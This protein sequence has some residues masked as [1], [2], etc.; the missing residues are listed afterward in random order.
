MKQKNV[1]WLVIA[2]ALV[3]LGGILFCIAMWQQDWN[4]SSLSTATYET[5]EYKTLESFENIVIV[6]NTADIQLIPA[7]TASVTC[8]E[9]EN[10]KHTV[11]VRDGTLYIE[12]KDETKWYQHIGINFTS[13][14]IQLCIPKGRYGSISIKGDTGDVNIPG[15][16]SF[17]RLDI[18]VDTGDVSVDASVTGRATI[19]TSTGAAGLKN[20]SVGDLSISVSTGTVTV[21]NVAC[22]GDLQVR[23]ST[24]KANL[25]NVTCKN[26]HSIGSTGDLSLKAV[27]GAEAMIIERSTGD[28]TFDRCD[29]AQLTVVTDTG[30]VTG[31][32]LSPKIFFCETDT[33]RVDVPKTTTGGTCQ[34]RTDTGSIKIKIAN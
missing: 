30:D 11:S 22:A 8:Y 34:I 16:F 17:A 12:I 5:N 1:L 27:I 10:A 25:T 26:L 13:P 31:T 6:T 3:L 28:V 2:T 29:A 32:L 14:K 24:G 21:S 4:F 19:R 20:A 9:Q 23:V 7:D 15:D 33:G 18:A